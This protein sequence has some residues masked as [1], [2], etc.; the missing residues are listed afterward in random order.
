MKEAIL[1]GGHPVLAAYGMTTFEYQ[2]CDPRFSKVFNNAMKGVSSLVVKHL[3]RKYNGFD[4]VRVL[5]D[6]GGNVG[7][8]VHMITCFHPHIKGI[9]FDLPHI[10]AGAPPLPGP[11]TDYSHISENKK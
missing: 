6:V 9:N 3:L 11:D 1:N 4:D 5:V 10:I 7:G 8:N 2:A